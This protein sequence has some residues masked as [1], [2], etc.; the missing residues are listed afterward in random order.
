[1]FFIVPL[2]LPMAQ[3]LINRGITK[4]VAIDFEESFPA[5]HIREKIELHD[6]K[7]EI[8][9]ITTNAAGW[10]REAIVRDYQ[11]SE[12]QL[13]KQTQLEQKRAQQEEQRTL[14]DKAK[15][16]Q[17]QRLLEALAD[18]PDSEQWVR[19]RV[20][21]HVRVRE[22]T[23]KSVGGEPFTDAEIKQM[24]LNYQAQVPTT[25]DQKRGWLISH[26]NQYALSSIISEFKEEQQQSL[27]EE[28]GALSHFKESTET[29]DEPVLLNSIE[30]VLVEVARQQVDF[31]AQSESEADK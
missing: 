5:E 6:Y 9:E 8:G 27:V 19:E 1:M 3:E 28:S 11:L 29:A 15:E 26:Y 16:I 21:E 20:V 18:F 10:L 30:D 31:E 13:K 7:K 12:G 14:E 25:D 24:Y 23:I 17:E 4:A 22:M 2:F